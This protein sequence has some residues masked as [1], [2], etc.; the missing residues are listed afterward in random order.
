M[1]IYF[2]ISYLPWVT[3]G[4]GKTIVLLKSEVTPDE[5]VAIKG[6]VQEFLINE[7]IVMTLHCMF[8]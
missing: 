6:E 5:K 2:C 4:V 7:F 8:A 3:I 1:S